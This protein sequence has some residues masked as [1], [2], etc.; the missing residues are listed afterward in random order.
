MDR[1]NGIRNT[2]WA[3]LVTG[4]LFQSWYLPAGGNNLAMA[5]TDVADSC[6]VEYIGVHLAENQPQRQVRWDSGSTH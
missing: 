2:H 6:Y 3:L 1:Q 5:R 4:E